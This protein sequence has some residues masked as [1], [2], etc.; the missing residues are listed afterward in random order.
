MDID[1]LPDHYQQIR[2]EVDDD[3]VAL[4]TLDRPEHMNAW[5]GQMSRELSH[6][7]R[8]CD[9]NDEV[10][11][12]VITGA[13]RAFC[14]GADLSHGGD[15]FSEARNQTAQEAVEELYPWD[16]RKPVI[17]A[18]N[19]AA[20]VLNLMI[21][22]GTATNIIPKYCRIDW[23]ARGV[24]GFEPSEVVDVED[25]DT[26]EYHFERPSNDGLVKYVMVIHE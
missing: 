6:A 14:A 25:A 7:L 24:P 11:V 4:L 5:T 12:V 1:G 20:E 10:R 9:Q 26:L 2:L 23:E 15:T 13:G 3:G 8:W 17:A 21:E 19:G 16:I 18:I 22:G